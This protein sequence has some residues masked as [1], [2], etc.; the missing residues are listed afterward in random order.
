MDKNLKARDSEMSMEILRQ[1]RN[2]MGISIFLPVYLLSGITLDKISFFGNEVSVQNPQIITISLFVLFF[3]FNLRYYQY[4]IEENHVQSYKEKIDTKTKDNIALFLKNR[5]KS[6]MGSLY[7]KNFV[8]IRLP[9]E[10]TNSQSFETAG[11]PEQLIPR[12]NPFKRSFIAI[13]RIFD[14]RAGTEK[15]DEA[16]KFLLEAYNK[17][18]TWEQV[19]RTTNQEELPEIFQT[20][21]KFGW[22]ELKYLKLQTWLHYLLQTTTITNYYTPFIM[23]FISA[24]FVLFWLVNQVLRFES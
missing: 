21:I 4:F 10:Y 6:K 5:I 22:V 15:P 8:S 9:A 20:D 23:A 3:Y 18:P 14:P 11:L 13:V 16:V 7:S 12:K 1:R 24:I 19:S 2:L 17:S